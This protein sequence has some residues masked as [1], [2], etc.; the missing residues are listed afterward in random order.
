M[1]RLHALRTFIIAAAASTAAALGDAPATTNPT[2][3]RHAEIETGSTA[4]RGDVLL[5]RIKTLS[6]DR[7][8]GRL[9]ATPSGEA[10]ADWIAGQFHAIGLAPGA[11]DGTYFQRVP[12]VGA[13]S[14]VNVA[15]RHGGSSETL[16][17]QRDFVAWA[18]G[19]GNGNV[20]ASE[21]VFVG[22]GVTAP[23]YQWDDFKGVDLK[24]KTLVILINDPPV[25]DK[26]NSAHLDTNMFRGEAMT[27]YGRWTYKYEKAA[28]LGAAAALIVHETKP[29]AYPW[30]V[31]V[32][33]WGHERF[34]IDGDGAACPRVAGWLSLETAGRLFAAAGFD[35]ATAKAMALRRDFKPVSLKAAADFSWINAARHSSSRN[36]VG[37]IRGSDPALRNEWLLYT[38]HWDHLGRDSRLQGDQIFNGAIDNASGTA[39]L[40]GLA[41]AFHA[42]PR[43]PKRSILFIATTAEEQGLL[44]ARYYSSHPIHPLARTVADFNLDGLN[45]HGRTRDVGVIGLGQSTLEDFVRP[46]ASSQHRHLV[47]DPKP[48]NG[49]FYRADH[50]E[51]A[52]VGVPALYM[53]S[54]VDYIGRP[55]GWGTAQLE[56]YIAHRYHKVTDEVQPDWD[57]SGAVED[58]QLLFQTGWVVANAQ[59]WPVWKSG[60]EFRGIRIQSLKVATGPKQ[61]H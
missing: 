7:Y 24:G 22:Y 13:S 44:G 60:S 53:K 6:D 28:A 3:G 11:G 48:E 34:D 32:N 20:S 57:M 4:I 10:A 38:A 50:F 19:D 12:L 5:Q 52:K 36:V 15:I 51:F 14:A 47:P 42:A 61:Q 43:P 18:P 39:G 27:Y 37:A 8:E 33:S 40:L 54:G 21:L 35:Y 1:A 9:P 46:L 23:E 45:V 17:P 29:A 16:T 59:V 31:V 26:A 25:P 55:K 58:L 49:T 56:D 2:G 41:D 30:E